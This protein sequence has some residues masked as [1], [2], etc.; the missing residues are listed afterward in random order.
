MG[1]VEPLQCFADRRQLI[2]RDRDPWYGLRE[3][4]AQAGKV[5]TRA[6]LSLEEQVERRPQVREPSLDLR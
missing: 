6:T 2:K 3:G 5:F 1:A 4:V